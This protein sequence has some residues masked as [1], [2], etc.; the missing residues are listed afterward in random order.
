MKL[1]F[2]NGIFLICQSK[3]HSSVLAHNYALFCR[4]MLPAA[5]FFLTSKSGYVMPIYGS[6][7]R[8]AQTWKRHVHILLS[9]SVEK[10]PRRFHL[11]ERHFRE[12]KESLVFAHRWSDG[13]CSIWA[14]RAR[15]G[16]ESPR[17][18][19]PKNHVGK[20]SVHS[21]NHFPSAEKK[22]KEKKK[23]ETRLWEASSCRRQAAAHFSKWLRFLAPYT[24][25]ICLSRRLTVDHVNICRSQPGCAADRRVSYCWTRPGRAVSAAVE[26]QKSIKKLL[27]CEV[28]RVPWIPFHP[29][30]CNIKLS[31][32][33]FLLHWGLFTLVLGNLTGLQDV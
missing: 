20:N 18:G 32:G 9:V 33:V 21:D 11:N 24:F 7:T 14:R 1:N 19:L 23:K 15:S 12:I 26:S 3:F 31:G 27:G 4:Q 10:L 22:R 5:R 8:W 29:S 30:E 28:W 13:C 16:C 2:K 6:S 17:T 25:S